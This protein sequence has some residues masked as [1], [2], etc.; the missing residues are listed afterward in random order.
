MRIMIYIMQ[1][2]QPLDPSGSQFVRYNKLSAFVDGSEPPLRISKPNLLLFVV[3]NLSICEND[4]MHFVNIVDALR[5]KFLGESD[6]LGANSQ[7]DDLPIDIRKDRPK[8]YYLVTTT[9]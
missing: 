7:G 2:K 9:M 1:K 8:D 4:R 3:V 5:K 6:I